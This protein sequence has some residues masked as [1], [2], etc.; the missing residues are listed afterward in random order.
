MYTQ[1]GGYRQCFSNLIYYNS[2]IFRQVQLVAYLVI[3]HSHKLLMI[4]HH[5]VI[6]DF[7]VLVSM[8]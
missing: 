1:L 8:F 3:A 7:L 6:K 2:I 5:L 4:H